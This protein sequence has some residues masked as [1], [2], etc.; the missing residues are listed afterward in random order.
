MISI[1]SADSLPVT[2]MGN[3]YCSD[4]RHHQW[5]TGNKYKAP[6]RILIYISA[7]RSLSKKIDIKEKEVVNFQFHV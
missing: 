6:N 5:Q 7:S 1:L 4:Q 2:Q 3:R